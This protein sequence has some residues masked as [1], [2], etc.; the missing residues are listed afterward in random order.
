M[1]L[2]IDP[3]SS[4]DTQ[5]KRNAYFNE[6]LRRV[7]EIPGVEAAGLSDALPLGR[8]RTWGVGAKGHVYPKDNYPEAFVR[9]V[10]DGYFKAMG[11]PIREGRDFTPADDAGEPKSDDRE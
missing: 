9:I 4:Y 1:A 8:N 10:S 2:R 3:D 11:I 5:E 7:L 6:A